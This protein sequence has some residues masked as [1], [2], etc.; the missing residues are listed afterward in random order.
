[1]TAPTRST[2]RPVCVVTGARGLVGSHLLP[3]LTATHDVVAI[4]RTPGPAQPHVQW[5]VAD[6]AGADWEQA[7]PAR[8]EAAVFLAQSRRFREFP[9]G[10]ADVLAV[11]VSAVERLAS[12]AV[13]AGATRF[14]HLSSGGVYTPSNAVLPEDA[15]LQAP[16]RAGWYTASKIAAESLVLA[17]AAHLAPIV[18]RPFFVY[19][20][21]QPRHMLVPR[22]ADAVRDGRPVTLSSDTGIRISLTHADDMA[23][24]IIGSLSLT[25]PH[26]LNVAGPDALTIREIAERFGVLLARTPV[27]EQAGVATVASDL[28][29]DR[30][31]LS[32]AMPCPH[33]PF[34]THAASVLY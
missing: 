34:A 25:A 16:E 13:T 9:A 24:A 14:V 4:T 20:A 18:L 29:A 31:R 30:S 33:R 12:H 1:M 28:V 3:R 22:I 8:Y 17:Y 5:V 6:L 32:A 23:D 26:V 19:G 10:A 15:A 7:L 11:N 27:F 2:P 21:G